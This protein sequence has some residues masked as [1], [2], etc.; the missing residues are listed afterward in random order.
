MPETLILDLQKTSNG[1]LTGRG[2]SFTRSA[3]VTGLTATDSWFDKVIA[4]STIGGLPLLGDSIDASLPLCI[5]HRKTVVAVTGTKVEL[6][7]EYTQASRTSIPPEETQ[8]QVGATLNQIETNIDVNGTRMSVAY[9]LPTPYQY[10]DGDN[11]AAGEVITQGGLVPKYIPNPTIVLTKTLSYSP[12]SLAAQYVGKLND[13]TW[14]GGAARTWM[15][16]GIVGNSDDSGD[17]YRVTY[18]FQ[19][20]IDTWDE[21]VMWHDPHDG[22][23]PADLVADTGYKTYQLY[24]VIDFDGLDL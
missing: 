22:K 10:D 14:E 5:L 2:W 4:A 11:F 7:L 17:T 24:P 18:T 15:C 12:L 23:P 9:T 19:Y 3:I 8:I 1:V 6:L 13:D 16:T 20:R 21:V